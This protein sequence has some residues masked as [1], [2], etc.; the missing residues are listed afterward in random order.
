MGGGF[1]D[2]VARQHPD[3]TAGA[4]DWQRPVLLG[5][6]AFDGVLSALV[7]AF[8]LPLYLG[9]VPFPISGL[10]SGLVNLALVWAASQW[11]TTPRLAALPVW[12]WLATVLVLAFA[13]PGKDIVFGG[14]GIMQLGP[15]VLL[16]L[17]AAPPVWY[18][19]RRTQ[20]RV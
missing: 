3:L 5:V 13:G 9:S 2:R 19:F 1:A 4:P 14:T 12:T 8:F 6:L 18:V 16:V 7:G 20:V 11:T 17:G 10:L 15:I